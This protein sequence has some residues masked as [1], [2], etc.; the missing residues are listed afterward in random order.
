M[1]IRAAVG[2]GEVG[3]DGGE[4]L[5]WQR[6]WWWWWCPAAATTE[7]GDGGGSCISALPGDASGWDSSR[8]RC[9]AVGGDLLT[10]PPTKPTLR[11]LLHSTHSADAPP[12]PSYWLGG[13]RVLGE[14]RWVTG[15]LV[16]GEVS[17]GEGG[18]E[19]ESGECLMVMVGESG[20]VKMAASPC[21]TPCPALCQLPTPPGDASGPPLDPVSNEVTPIATH[22]FLTPEDL[23][24]A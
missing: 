19:G 20:S 1:A 8:A 9:R 3:G 12:M 2:G 14:W 10:T 21:H 15:G 5:D 11:P 13:R 23:N 24:L 17:E 22:R 4:G 16:E 7:G 18:S 6:W